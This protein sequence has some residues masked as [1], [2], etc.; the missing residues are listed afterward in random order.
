MTIDHIYLQLIGYD[1]W[2]KAF[3]CILIYYFTEKDR[4]PEIKSPESGV[5]VEYVL[6]RT[7][8]AK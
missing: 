3:Y 8:T 4:P 7:C 1:H 2:A 6:I 5:D